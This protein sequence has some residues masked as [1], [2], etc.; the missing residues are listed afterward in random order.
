MLESQSRAQKTPILAWFPKKHEP[1]NSSLC[2]RP[3]TD[4]VGQKF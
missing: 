4:K 3:R 2:W 1:K